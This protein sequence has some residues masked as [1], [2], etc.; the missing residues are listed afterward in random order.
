MNR[1]ILR[2]SK[3]THYLIIFSLLI[4]MMY[5]AAEIIIPLVVAMY[6][7]LLLYPACSFIE[8]KLPRIP[9]IILTFIA[10]FIIITGIVFFFSSQFL[11]LFESIRNFGQNLNVLINKFFHIIDTR[12]TAWGTA[13]KTFFRKQSCKLYRI[14]PHPSENHNFF[15]K[16]CSI[17]WTGHSLHFPVPALS[18]FFQ[19]SV[20]VSFFQKRQ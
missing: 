12:Y 6:L 11:H 9:S 10:V 13:N 19:K 5:L 4:A 20:P 3:T 18:Y 16:F 8:K 7:S 2:L 14:K 15:F 17:F 1:D